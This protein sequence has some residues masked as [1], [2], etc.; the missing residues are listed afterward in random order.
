MSQLTKV[1]GFAATS[2]SPHSEA[3]DMNLW[4]M[5]WMYFFLGSNLHFY[6]FSTISSFS[7]H[8]LK[9]MWSIGSLEEIYILLVCY[10]TELNQ[11]YTI[12]LSKSPTMY[13]ELA[14]TNRLNNSIYDD[15]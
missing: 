13:F 3:F 4:V 15:A 7:I 9:H 11:I 6:T 12:D 8:A 1:N 5:K 10:C 2:A 14:T